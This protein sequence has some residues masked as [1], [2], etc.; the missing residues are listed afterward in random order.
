MKL[1]IKSNTREDFCLKRMQKVFKAQNS[2]ELM[3]QVIEF[4]Y[5]TVREKELQTVGKF[6]AENGYDSE[7]NMAQGFDNV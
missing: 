1:E 4:A 7:M 5:A 3:R 6:Q 2:T